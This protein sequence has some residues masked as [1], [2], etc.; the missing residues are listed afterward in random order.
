[1]NKFQT[2]H[3]ISEALQQAFIAAKVTGIDYLQNVD[4]V[5]STSHEQEILERNRL[6]NAYFLNRTSWFSNG[7]LCRKFNPRQQTI[8]EF[9]RT[10]KKNRELLLQRG[11]FNGSE[12]V[13]FANGNPRLEK[14]VKNKLEVVYRYYF[15]N[16]NLNYQ[17][18]YHDKEGVSCD[19][20]Y[21]MEGKLLKKYFLANGSGKLLHFDANGKG[22]TEF[23]FKHHQ[24]IGQEKK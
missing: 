3:F 1:M 16:G 15:K 7:N 20:V 11:K 17:I 4:T 10:G 6:F 21:D 13:F 19:A 8:E 23:I 9:Y 5:F 24:M 18:R 2:D 22:G 12:R 14:L